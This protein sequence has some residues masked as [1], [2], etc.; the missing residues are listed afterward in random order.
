MTIYPSKSGTITCLKISQHSATSPYL[1]T[2]KGRH[3]VHII[4]AF[5]HLVLY[6]IP[7]TRQFVNQIQYRPLKGQ[8]HG[9]R[10]C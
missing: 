3:H 7:V 5:A 9:Q 4:N 2:I 1:E 6:T 8:C 10:L